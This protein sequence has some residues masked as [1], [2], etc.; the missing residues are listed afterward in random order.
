MI[1]TYGLSLQGTSH[2]SADIVCQD[3]HRIK[4]LRNGWVIAAIADGVGSSKHSDIAAKIAVDT[5]IYVIE[6]GLMS[7]DIADVKHLMK[8][9]FITALHNIRCEAN[10]RNDVIKNYDTTL[11]AVIYDG[12]RIVYGHV[13]DG[14]IIGLTLSGEYIPVT[15]VQKGDEH[16]MVIPLRAGLNYWVF[17][18]ADEKFASLMLFTDGLLDIAMPS[19][20]S[21]GVYVRFTQQF[22]E[23]SP[24][25]VK[26]FLLSDSCKPITDDKTIVAIINN[27]VTADIKDA[28][29]Y[30]EPDWKKL[31]EEKYKLLYN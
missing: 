5:V 9:G 30:A 16:N 26:T 17:G 19:L 18:I 11:T 6:T 22:I 15:K 3:A 7:A 24:D 2:I 28:D 13:G 1:F 8:L 20:L 23:N 12:E 29:Y 21:G 4:Q 31:R 27:N 10:I 14:G 25:Q